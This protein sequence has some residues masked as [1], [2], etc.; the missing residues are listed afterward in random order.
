MA[1]F[2]F[3]IIKE[4][5]KLVI[6][7]SLWFLGESCRLPS[8]PYYF[9]ALILMA[10]LGCTI[11]LVFFYMGILGGAVSHYVPLLPA[12]EASIR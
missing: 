9:E 11:L 4:G 12:M 6:V 10:M 1:V 5:C 8:S 7:S 3:Y 2:S